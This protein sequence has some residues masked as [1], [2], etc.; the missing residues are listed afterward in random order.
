MNPVHRY[1]FNLP[2]PAVILG[3]I[4]YAGLAAYLFFLARDF[5]GVIFYCLI[6][7]SVVFGI[8]GVIM[9]ARRLVFPR[10]LELTDEAILY[11][12]GFPRTRIITVPYADILRIA[13][14]CEGSQ[15]GLTAVT[16]RGTFAITVSYFKEVDNY[17]AVKDFISTKT[18]VAMPRNGKR[19]PL[20]WGD[21]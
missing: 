19:E 18:S 7:L 4:F 9:L 14:H 17:H 10:M 8:L 2:W 5:A 12:R 1:S 20:N 15:T 21:W 13:N 6:A 16:G 3:G 11:P